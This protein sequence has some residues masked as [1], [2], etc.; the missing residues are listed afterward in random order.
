MFFKAGQKGQNAWYL[1]L[2]GVIFIAFGYLLGQMPLAADLLI[3]KKAPQDVMASG[4]MVELA[5]LYGNKNYFLFLIM[6]TFIAASLVTWFVIKVI[7]RKKLIDVLSGYGTFRWKRFW[8]AFLIPLCLIS[9]GTVATYFIDP[10]SLTLQFDA[11]KFAV[12]AIMG[13]ILFPIQAGWEEVFFRGYLM[14]G[15]GNLVRSRWFALLIT[16]LIFAAM[17]MANPEVVEHGVLAMFPLYAGMGLMFGIM[18]LMDNGL[19]LAMG[20]HIAN[21]FAIALFITSPESA[22]QTDS[23]FRSNE[24]ADPQSSAIQLL[25]MGSILLAIFAWK[26]K[27]KDWGHRLAGHIERPVEELNHYA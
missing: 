22:L 2:V 5:N 7:H 17:H 25:V 1:Y 10:E 23:V 16:T 15:L 27:W 13:A 18:V 3:L 11:K 4:D 24:V 14:Q 8:F 6:L 26:Y 12:L 21:N 9:L 20:Y 19:E